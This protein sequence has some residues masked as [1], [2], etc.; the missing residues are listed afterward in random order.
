MM[1]TKKNIFEASSFLKHVS[2]WI[3]KPKTKWWRWYL[4]CLSFININLNAQRNRFLPWL[5]FLFPYFKIFS[6]VLAQVPQPTCHWR[7]NHGFCNLQFNTLDIGLSPEAEIQMKRRQMEE[8]K[9][10]KHCWGS[11]GRRNFYIPVIVPDLKTAEQMST[12]VG[13]EARRPK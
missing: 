2:C 1:D 6:E 5:E 7:L 12:C 13:R 3:K 10:P 4:H 11:A 8:F 9:Q